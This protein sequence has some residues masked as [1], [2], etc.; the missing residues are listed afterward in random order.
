MLGALLGLIYSVDYSSPHPQVTIDLCASTRSCYLFESWPIYAL[1]S[2]RV[3]KFYD[4]SI[5]RHLCSRS[6]ILESTRKTAISPCE[7]ICFE[8]TKSFAFAGLICPFEKYCIKGCPCEH[9]RCKKIEFQQEKVPVWDLSKRKTIAVPDIE[10]KDIG[11]ITK[12]N[13]D[14]ASLTGENRKRHFIQSPIKLVDLTKKD[15]LTL[16]VSEERLFSHE[17]V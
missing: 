17:I 13:K 6:L 12:R 3:P 1:P 7:K 10:E 11:L 16:K 2:F 8:L 9:Y 4:Q 5:C 15:T 14:Y